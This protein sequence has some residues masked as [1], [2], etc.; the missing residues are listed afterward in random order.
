M[1]D[2]FLRVLETQPKKFSIIADGFGLRLNMKA[3]RPEHRKWDQNPK[4]TPLSEATSIVAPFIWESPRDFSNSKTYMFVFSSAGMMIESMAGKSASLNGTVYDATPFTFS[5][6][7]PAV[8]YF[9]NLLKQCTFYA[10]SF[11]SWSLQMSIA[12]EVFTIRFHPQAQGVL[13]Y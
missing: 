3:F 2:N 6:D 4:F 8:D 9:G 7:D 12:E 5:E 11:F 1:A 10:S 13:F